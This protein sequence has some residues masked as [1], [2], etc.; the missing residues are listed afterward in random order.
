MLNNECEVDK[1]INDFMVYCW[2]QG[3]WFDQIWK[4][5]E[6]K[7]LY[8]LRSINDAAIVWYEGIPEPL[9]DGSF[10]ETDMEQWINLSEQSGQTTASILKDITGFYP[11][12]KD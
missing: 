9:E 11:I 10:S 3:C 2:Y 12:P 5:T 7:W 1:Q 6:G 4:N 8:I